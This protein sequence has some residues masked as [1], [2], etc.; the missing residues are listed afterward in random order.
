M[1]AILWFMLGALFTVGT[2]LAAL[3]E[4]LRVAESD[5]MAAETS[6]EQAFADVGARPDQLV[7]GIRSRF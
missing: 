2:E 5:V 7:Q 1:V 3:G 4:I 6:F